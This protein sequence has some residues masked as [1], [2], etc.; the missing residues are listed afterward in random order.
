MSFYVCDSVLVIT[1]GSSPDVTNM[2]LLSCA[3]YRELPGIF[4]FFISNMG[5]CLMLKEKN[6]EHD[7][8]ISVFPASY[9]SA[10]F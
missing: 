9:S 3:M 8:C 2:L 7:K 1:G 5:Q 6:K 10:T 4:F